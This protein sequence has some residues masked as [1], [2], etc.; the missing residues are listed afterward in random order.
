[1]R[2][3]VEKLQLLDTP[4]EKAHMINEVPEVHVDPHMAPN[5]ES[6][7]EQ[8]YK[9]AGTKSTWTVPILEWCALVI[10]N[11]CKFACWFCMQLIGQ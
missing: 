6:A 3:C 7:E 5:Y 1:M 8:D 11:F 10:L 2:E 9:K 4:E